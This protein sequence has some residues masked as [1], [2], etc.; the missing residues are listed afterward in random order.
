MGTS[1]SADLDTGYR[2]PRQPNWHPLVTGRA[3]TTFAQGRRCA[4]ASCDT[5]LSRYNPEDTCTLH[6]GW[7]DQPT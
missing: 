3:P 6:G 4:H 1:I 2:Q 5:R 7:S